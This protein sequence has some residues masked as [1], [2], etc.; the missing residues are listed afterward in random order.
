MELK[1][2]LDEVTAQNECQRRMYEMS[3]A[4]LSERI[5]DL[6][7]QIDTE[8]AVHAANVSFLEKHVTSLQEQVLKWD[9]R[10]T[11]DSLSKDRE[12]ESLK[13]YHLRDKERLKAVVNEYQR[14]VAEKE[15]R[16]TEHSSSSNVG[17]FTA[18]GEKM[19]KYTRCAKIIQQAWKRFVERRSKE[20]DKKAG[21]KAG[22]KA[23]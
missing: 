21:K 17:E 14:A 16:E 12:L 23:K 10:M 2:R 20:K 19:E 15:R 8:K 5:A 18:D 3:I 11:S 6:E 7:K 4:N 22:K 9:E 13:E 1:Y